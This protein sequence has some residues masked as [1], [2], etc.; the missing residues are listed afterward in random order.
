M[1]RKTVFVNA[2]VTAMELHEA[3]RQIADIRHQMALGTVYRG[4]RA[5]TVGASG[6]LALLAA[7]IQPRWVPEPEGDL[8]R[9]LGL[10]VGAA[11]ASLVA[12]GVEMSRRAWGHGPGLARRMTL[13]AAEQFLPCVAVGAL[14]TTCIARGAPD[15]AWML[16]GLW[17]LVFSLGIFA[18]HRLLPRP[19]GWVGVYYAL[20]GCGCLAWGRGEHALAPWLMGITFGGGQLL[21]AAILHWTL[22]R[23]DVTQGPG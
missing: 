20:C 13:L 2:R 15:A 9:Y 17:A 12:A 7:A 1:Q 6:V 3:L 21:G 16:P 14:L 19:V 18:S 10:W 23:T 8:G 5:M 11:A 4:Y 22:E